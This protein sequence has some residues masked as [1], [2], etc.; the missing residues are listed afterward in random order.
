MP[1]RDL[2]TTDL[3]ALAFRNIGHGVAL[4]S[5]ESTLLAYNAA[6]SARFDCFGGAVPL[7]ITQTEFFNRVD[8][9][10]LIVRQARGQNAKTDGLGATILSFSD[11]TICE[12]ERW[13]AEDGTYVT[14]YLDV[15]VAK[16]SE[17]ALERARDLAASADQ[18]KSRFLRAAN[19]DLRQPL[20][21]L[22]ILIYSCASSRNDEERSQ[23]LHA[24]DVSVSI[25]EDLLGALLNIG[26]LDAGK[27]TPQ[28]QTFQIATLLDRLRVQYAHQASEKGIALRIM[29]S[30]VAVQSDRALLER[31]ISNF[32]GNAIRYTDVGRVLVGCSR[33]GAFLRIGVYDTG[34]GIAEEHHQAI[35]D[36][37]F[38]IAEDQLYAKHSLGLGLNIAKRLADVLGHPIIMQSTLGKGSGFAVEVPIGN[39]WHSSLGEPEINEKI[40]GEFA[41]LVALILEDDN[42]LRN[43][44]TTLLERW[45]IEVQTFNS[46]DNIPAALAEFDRVPDIII[47][48]YR[49]RGDVQGTDV[50]NQVNDI[51]EKPCPA[52]VVTADT[53][54]DLIAAIRGQGFPVLIKPVSPPSLRVIM[55]NLLFEPEMVPEIS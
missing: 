50:V 35:F 40:G 17:R 16:R 37:F 28:V 32:V 22:K 25:M 46:F 53:S 4:W 52:V 55:H 7:G 6:F 1:A 44:L 14:F 24:M 21:S 2:A 45:G 48:D 23:A 11:G 29:P 3:A 30:K 9:A 36:E 15:T 43:A 5:A 41:G 20:A 42:N 8:R 13:P 10:G 51:L 38:R 33:H 31:I 12:V 54:P 19:H 39:V 26:Q 47:T 27:V 34:R 49:L 18:G